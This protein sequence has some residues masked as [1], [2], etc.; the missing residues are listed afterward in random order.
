MLKEEEGMGRVVFLTSNPGG[1][2]KEEG[3]RVACELDN[4]NQFVDKLKNI[5]KSG[6]KCLLISSNPA[7]IEVNDGMRSILREAFE[8]S[9]LPAA[10]MEVWDDRKREEMGEKV[11]NFD[12]LI[13]AGGHVPT[14]NHFFREIGLKGRIAGYEGIV[15][16]ISAGTM[17]S[18]EVVYAAPEEEGESVDENYQRFLPGLGLTEVMILPHFQML[19]DCM[20][21]GKSVLE[22][23]I[24]PDSAG[25]TFCA[26]P[27]GS[28]IMIRD[29]EN[30]GKPQVYGE[31]Y[32]ICDGACTQICS[33]GESREWEM[34]RGE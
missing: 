10:S 20:L 16:G 7:A 13:L 14:Q 27:D 33:D 22:D 34:A 18:A 21:D 28:Y 31:S 17:N 4:R 8:M 19:K 9:G 15:I 24:Y 30:G 12:V 11:C 2:Y 26:L 5:W 3:R 25:K 29:D 32:W 1:S 23:I 6:A